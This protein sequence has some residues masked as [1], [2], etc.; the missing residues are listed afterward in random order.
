METTTV[1]STV[2][3]IWQKSK[4]IIKGGIIGL[5]ALLFMIPMMYVENLVKERE[6]RQRQ[7]TNEISSKWAGSQNIAEP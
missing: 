3:M 7:V 6:E 2:S 4:W 5:M 1:T